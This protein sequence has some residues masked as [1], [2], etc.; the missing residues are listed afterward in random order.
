M[1]YPYKL[2]PRESQ[3]KAMKDIY[4]TKRRL[5]W[6]VPGVGKTKIAID[7]IGVLLN[8]K[9]IKRALIIVPEK[10]IP[11]WEEQIQINAPWLPVQFFH[12]DSKNIS[13]DTDGVILTNYEFF[14]PRSKTYIRRDGEKDTYVNKHRRDAALL[15]EPELVCIDEGHRIKNPYTRSAK[16]VHLLGNVCEYAIDLTG[17]PTGNKKRLDMWSHFRF[18]VPDLLDG[19]FTKHKRRYGIYGGFGGFKLLKERNTKHLDKKIKPWITVIKKKGIEQK[20]FIPF[21]VILPPD[22]KKLYDQMEKDFLI[23][24]DSKEIVAS[25]ALTKLAKCQ[26]I[27]G[28]FIYDDKKQSHHIHNAKLE[29]VDEITEEL[30]ESGIKSCLIFAR[31]L[32]EIDAIVSRV[33]K[34]WVTYRITGKESAKERK[35]A[36]SMFNEAG[37]IAVCQIATGSEALS[38]KNCDYE[39][40][41]STDHSYIHFTQATYRIDRDEVTSPKFYYL[42]QAK[43]TVDSQIYRCHRENKSL[44]DELRNFI[45][46]GRE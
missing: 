33:A 42:L 41:Y 44:A 43:G 28:G 10:A 30:K 11:V 7:F 40:F 18:L 32:S 39:I 26:Q 22:A 4:R 6:G 46:R 19:R 23:Y 5:I 9:K 34:D 13:W 37:G 27:A 24:L 35:L 20:T 25:I 15:W 3:L 8:R 12:S 38:F 14:S 31:Y 36:E 45:L 1:S 21:P 16:T 17:T 29:A 2:K